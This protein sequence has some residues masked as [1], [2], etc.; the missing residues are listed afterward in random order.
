MKFS[1]FAAFLSLA[2][3]ASASSIASRQNC[4]EATRFGVVIVNP[5]TVKPGD[6][7]N[8]SV[9]F[10]CGVK[11]FGIIPSFLDFTIEVSS[12]ANN[13][14][15]QPIVLARRT[16]PAGALSDSFTTTIPHGFY[17]ANAP[18]N[19]VLTNIYNIDGTDGSPV[20]VEGGVL[21]FI[22]IDV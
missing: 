4:P 3:F 5:T 21:H 22:D 16:I 9:D 13:G 18:Y 14:F 19:I 15:E 10:T 11:T 20:L 6:T 7:I 8:I 12:D 17:V 1:I 2:G